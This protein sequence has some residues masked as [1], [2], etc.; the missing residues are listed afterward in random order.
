MKSYE[1]VSVIIL[2]I[3]NVMVFE[4]KTYDIRFG[5][6]VE[7]VGCGFGVSTQLR[8]LLQIAFLEADAFFLAKVMFLVHIF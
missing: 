5:C 6:R 2:V 4:S 1:P 8:N 3:C 7:F